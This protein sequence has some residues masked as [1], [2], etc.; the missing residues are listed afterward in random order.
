MY[1]HPPARI[2]KSF[3][4]KLTEVEIGRSLTL[5]ISYETVV[6]FAVD[7]EGRF[8]ARNIWGPTTGRH[9]NSIWT[10]PENIL[11]HSEL[12]ERLAEIM[13]RVDEAVSPTPTTTPEE[14]NAHQH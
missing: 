8:K 11:E 12:I 10:P 4:H 3:N 1:D 9:L 13:A 14:S 6:A 2:Y 5:W 7:G